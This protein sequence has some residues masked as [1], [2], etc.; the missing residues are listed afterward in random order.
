MGRHLSPA[1]ASILADDVLGVNG[2]AA[3]WVD[4]NT[5]KTGISLMK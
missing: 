2:Q 1:L 3:V 5:E 4:S